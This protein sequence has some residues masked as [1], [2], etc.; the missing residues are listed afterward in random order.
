MIGG[1]LVVFVPGMP[2]GEK[3][4]IQDCLLYAEVF[5][6]R[7]SGK[8]RWAWLSHYQYALLNLGLTL[9][10]YIVERPLLISNVHQVRE[11]SSADRGYRKHPAPG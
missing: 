3:Q 5:A 2:E 11:L 8:Q 1:T 4:D 7:G 9:T 6:N 10:S